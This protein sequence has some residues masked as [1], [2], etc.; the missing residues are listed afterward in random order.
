MANPDHAPPRSLLEGAALFL[1]FDGTL[2]ELAET[3][4]AIE[5][6]SDLQPLLERLARR[7]GG[8]LAIVSG[9]PIED[10]ERHLAI[11]GIAVSGSHGVE[12]RLAGQALRAAE[13]PAGVAEARAAARRFAETA[14]G[15]LVE[16]K[17]AGVALHYRQAPDRAYSVGTFMAAVA[18]RTGLSLLHGKMVAELR[19]RG[20][21]KGA[22]IR[23]MMAEPPF[24]GARPVFVGD[25]ITD[26]DGFQVASEMGGAGI[27]VGPPRATRA[28]W[29]LDD[30]PAVARWLTDAGGDKRV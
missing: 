24:A 5:V 7:L 21:D 11:S 17:P 16:E 1:D 26:E 23:A 10:L 18:E 14:P 13:P 4:D 2:V 19:P 3:P 30:V 22:A 29:R 28:A 27:L 15:L 9:R 8:R 6:S 12:L 25:D 20:A